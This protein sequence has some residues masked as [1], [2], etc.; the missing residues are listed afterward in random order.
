MQELVNDI[1]NAI[2]EI[3]RSGVSFKEFR[4]GVGPF[5][6]PQLAKLIANHLASK[7]SDS[8]GGART[9]RSPDVLIPGRWAL[10]FKIVRPFGDNGKEAESWSQ[11][12]LHPYPGNVSAI[13]DVLK[14]LARAGN[15]K[16]GVIVICYK[17]DPPQI[18]LLPLVE[19]FE[20]V[21]RQL[22]HLPLGQRCS[23]TV[24]GCIH[25]IHARALVFGWALGPQKQK[26]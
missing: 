22:F 17:H 18:D 21:S 23:A 2:R 12:L 5:G 15:E 3:D 10:E 8:Y 9:C 25:P 24:T 11:N 6:E 20:L 16:R 1:A 14:L 13:G 19:A 26:K 7:C 4:P